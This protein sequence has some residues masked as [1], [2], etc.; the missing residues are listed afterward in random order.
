MARSLLPCSKKIMHGCIIA[1]QIHIVKQP[2]LYHKHPQSKKKWQYYF[3][4]VLPFISM[5]GH[6]VQKHPSGK[7]YL[8]VGEK[9]VCLVLVLEMLSSY[10]CQYMYNCE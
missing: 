4:L 3:G 8:F 2:V 9:V 7:S 6:P 5:G 10:V 1:Y